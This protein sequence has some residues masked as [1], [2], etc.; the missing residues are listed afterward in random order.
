MSLQEFQ[1]RSRKEVVALQG[2]D[3]TSL[4]AW[5]LLCDASRVEFQQIYD[6]LDI[7]VM[8][9]GESFYNPFLHDVIKDLQESGL[10]EVNM[11]VG[12]SHSRHFWAGPSQADEILFR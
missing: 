10:Y 2:G 7:D 12:L 5:K 6:M 1:D 9:R 11:F 4:K 3:E 8:E